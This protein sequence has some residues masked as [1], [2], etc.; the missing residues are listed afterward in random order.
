MV[1]HLAVMYDAFGSVAVLQM[2]QSL[3]IDSRS[4]RKSRQR[5]VLCQPWMLCVVM[6]SVDPS[7]AVYSGISSPEG[8]TSLLTSKHCCRLSGSDIL[9]CWESSLSSSSPCYNN[10]W[11]ISGLFEPRLCKLISPQGRSWA[12]ATMYIINSGFH[13]HVLFCKY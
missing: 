1:E 13:S 10:P 3:T 12:Q 9:V 4:D 11:S 2:R 8:S 5:L 6:S 7:H